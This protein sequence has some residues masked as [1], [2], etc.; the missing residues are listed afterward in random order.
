[1]KESYHTFTPWLVKSAV[2][3]QTASAKKRISSPSAKVSVLGYGG[4]SRS[5]LGPCSELR[6]G[7]E[8]NSHFGIPSSGHLRSILERK[9]LACSPARPAVLRPTIDRI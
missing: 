9:I 6:V 1:M 8:I 3:Y 4:S 2:G 5:V 7:A